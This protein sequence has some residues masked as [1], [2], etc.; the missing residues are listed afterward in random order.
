MPTWTPSSRPADAARLGPVPDR[1]HGRR[2]ARV[3][4]RRARAHG[5]ARRAP[6]GRRRWP[7]RASRTGSCARRRRV[8]VIDLR[9]DI[10]GARR[11]GLEARLR[12]GGRAGTRRRSSSTSPASTTSTPPGIALIVGLL[13]RPRRDGS[14]VSRLRPV[15]P[16]PGDLRDHPAVRLHPRLRR[17]A[18]RRER[19][20][21]EGR[22]LSTTSST[23]RDGRATAARVDR[24]HRRRD[25]GERGRLMDAYGRAAGDGVRGIVLDFTGLDYMN[26]SG[27]G[28]LVTLLVRA[29]REDQQLLRLRAVGPLPAD[30]R[31]D[32]ARRG[33]QR[34]RRRGRGA[35][36]GR[37]FV[38]LLAGIGLLIRIQVFHDRDRAL[39][40]V[41]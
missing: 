3:G 18:E 17:R 12:R 40:A 10:D 1:E 11:G 31:A 33:H 25:G 29:Q 13:A 22:C 32:P 27:I 5:R 9:G 30:L 16:L 20:G 35:G 41:S 8:A 14:E 39:P 38:R 19:R 26:S 4:E 36:R 24:A 6:G 37:R 15:R 34:A 2:D 28:L 23:M 21:P 7:R